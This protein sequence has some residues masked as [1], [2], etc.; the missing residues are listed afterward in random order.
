MTSRGKSSPVR[1]GDLIGPILKQAESDRRRPEALEVV[2]SWPEMVNAKL[3]RASRA[4]SLRDGKLFVEVKSPVWK[5]ELLLQRR[6]IIRKINRRLG[7]DIVSDM[8]INVRDYICR[9]KTI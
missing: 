5:Q 9:R 7:K 6:N 3:A 1:I 4:V 8:V 2:T